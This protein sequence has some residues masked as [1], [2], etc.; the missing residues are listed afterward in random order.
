MKP[1]YYNFI[2]DFQEDPEKHVFYNARTNALALV[3]KEQYAAYQAFEADHQAP[4]D[5]E[6]E[7]N[8]KYGGYIVDDDYNELDAIKY[9]MLN[10]RYNTKGLGLTI[11]PTSDCNFR[12]VYCYE[13]DSQKHPPMSQEV[14]D[15]IVEFVKAKA[16]EITRLSISWY[17]GEPL[18]ALS[19]IEF[20]TE[21]FLEICEQHNIQYSAGMITNGYLLTKEVA[22]KLNDMK[23]DRIQVTLDGTAEQHNKRRPL[24]GGGP[25]FDVIVHNLKEIKDTYKGRIVLRVNT[26]RTNIKDVPQI[27]DIVKKAGLEATVM[28]YLARV[29]NINGCCDSG[30]CYRPEE[31]ADI[32]HEFQDQ[33]GKLMT[34][35]PML[36][37][38]Y[39]GADTANSFVIDADGLMYK[40][41]NDIG[42]SERSVQRIGEA[43]VNE[44]QLYRYMLFDPTEVEPCTTCKYLPICMGGCPGQ[45]LQNGEV[46]CDMIRYSLDKLMRKLPKKME[47]KK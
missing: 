42:I 10:A 14:Q 43:G 45:R 18:L 13:K 24:A 15:K 5:E 29:E 44:K 30:E 28:P 35:Y 9:R 23:V 46:K 32:E 25:T 41:W 22:N 34:A 37:S 11:A 33:T 26:D 2:Y 47:E 12:C 27:T 21:K 8:L 6:F 7:K 39:C 19:V 1:S 3:E 20:L 40:C 4:L 38:K 31:F 36:K 17:G 16:N